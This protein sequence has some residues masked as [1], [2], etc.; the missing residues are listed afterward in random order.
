MMMMIEEDSEKNLSP[1]LFVQYIFHVDYPGI[2][3]GPP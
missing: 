2:E 1:R 3:P